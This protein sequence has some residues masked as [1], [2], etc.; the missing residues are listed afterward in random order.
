MSIA[1]FRVAQMMK[2]PCL[3]F[4]T[5]GGRSLLY[6]YT[7]QGDE[8]VLK[9]TQEVPTSIS[10]DDYL[11]L[12][13]GTYTSEPPRNDFEQQVVGT[14]RA[15]PAITEVLTSL[16]P[17][18]LEALEIDFLVRCGN[19]VGIGEV[20]TKGDK[21]G[22][23]RINAV[24]QQQYLGTYIRKFLISAKTVNYNNKELA[25]A[26]QIEVIEL[27]SYKRSGTLDEQDKQKLVETIIRQLGGR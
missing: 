4:Q 16:R 3:Y 9:D 25:R 12:Y 5:E 15:T 17:Q 11:R 6:Y 22:I 18:G 14:L 7:F 8:L 21:A 13:V 2:S 23:D 1:A 24:A 27:L 19:Q 10:L 26:Y 20:K